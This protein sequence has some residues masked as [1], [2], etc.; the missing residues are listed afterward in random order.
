[1]SSIMSSLSY[2]SKFYFKVLVN[3]LEYAKYY[4]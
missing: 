2:M 4:V 3:L 1:M